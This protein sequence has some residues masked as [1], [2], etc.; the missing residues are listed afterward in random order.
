[1]NINL[2]KNADDNEGDEK[3]A[4]LAYLEEAKSKKEKFV[5]GLLAGIPSDQVSKDVLIEAV[6]GIFFQSF[7]IRMSITGRV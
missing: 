6:K 4:A 2:L 7:R 5:N 1:M 3:K